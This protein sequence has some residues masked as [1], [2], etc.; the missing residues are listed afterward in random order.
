MVKAATGRL[1]T[2]KMVAQEMVKV[3]LFGRLGD[4]HSDNSFNVELGSEVK[5]V[6]DVRNQLSN[7]FPSLG[8]ALA[9]PQTLIAVNQ[10]IVDAGHQLSIGDELAFL[11]PVT[12]G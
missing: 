6:G 9:E 8:K 5:T 7:D 12:G 11:P 1:P 10:K 3:L 2:Q 4:L